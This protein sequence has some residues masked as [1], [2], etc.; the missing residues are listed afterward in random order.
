MSA[1]DGRG[2]HFAQWVIMYNSLL[3]K[4]F[5]KFINLPKPFTLLVFLILFPFQLFSN[6]ILGLITIIFQ[7]DFSKRTNNEVILGREYVY[8]LLN[9]ASNKGWKTLIIGGSKLG[10][11]ITQKVISKIF[12]N[13]KLITW[14]RDSKS[15]LMKDQLLPEF[16]GSTINNENICQIFPDLWEA[17]N[18]IKKTKPDLILVCLGGASG[19]QEFFLHYLKEDKE[20]KFKLAA[21]VGAAVDHLGGGNQ[22]KL[23][24][25]WM[26][27]SGLEWFFRFLTTP[28]RRKR[29]LDSIFTLWWWLTVQQFMNVSLERKTVVNIL[30]N[31]INQYLLV[32]RRN[33]LPGDLGWS[34]VQGGI[35]DNESAQKAGTREIVEEVMLNSDDLKTHYRPIIG[36]T[37]PHTI[38]FIRFILNGAKFNK[39]KHYLNFVQYKGLENPKNNWE[40]QKSKWVDSKDVHSKLSIEK[41]SDWMIAQEYILSKK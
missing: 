27:N 25:S 19:K 17:R 9:I 33:L 13:L 18:H 34:F 23:A 2:L 5:Q 24:P 8:D 6:L 29:I 39:S 15:L 37:E 21:G 16:I 7:Y 10:D 4:I 32:K 40:N 12:P 11:E 20:I 35:E 26:V 3:V 22:Q 31:K 38:S 1:I 30:S 14:T 36:Q 41:R 28:S